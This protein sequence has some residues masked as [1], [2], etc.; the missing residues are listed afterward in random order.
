MT[1]YEVIVVGAGPGGIAAATAASRSGCRVLLLDENATPGGQ[2][3][4]T[5]GPM[6]KQ[7]TEGEATRGRAVDRLQASGA[8]FLF[9]YGV[10]DAPAAGELR[11]ICESGE[12]AD[13]PVRGWRSRP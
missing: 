2:I 11:A 6:S 10:F 5:G 3:W 7:Q 1:R 4:R 8:S 9:G 12:S 13:D